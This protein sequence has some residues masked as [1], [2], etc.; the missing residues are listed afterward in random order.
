MD[1]KTPPIPL[2][3]QEKPKPKQQ[4]ETVAD[5]SLPPL[6]PHRNHRPRQKTTGTQWSRD[7]P[8]GIRYQ[9]HHKKRPYRYTLRGSICISSGH[10]LE[11][12]SHILCEPRIL[13]TLGERFWKRNFKRNRGNG[14]PNSDFVGKH[15]L[16]G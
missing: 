2:K 11:R 16:R 12:L 6:T 15:F 13:E 5:V 1:T 14:K 10:C 8:S 4:Q 3:V 9:D 7:A